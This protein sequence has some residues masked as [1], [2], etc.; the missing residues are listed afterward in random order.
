M[1][2]TFENRHVLTTTHAYNNMTTQHTY[3]YSTDM[4]WHSSSL[5]ILVW[6]AMVH[7]Q[8]GVS[9]ALIPICFLPAKLSKYQSLTKECL[10]HSI[11]AFPLRQMSLQVV[12]PCHMLSNCRQYQTLPSLIYYWRHCAYAQNRHRF[13]TVLFFSESSSWQ[14]TQNNFPC[15]T[16]RHLPMNSFTWVAGE[17]VLGSVWEGAPAFRFLSKP[18]LFDFQSFFYMPNPTFWAPLVYPE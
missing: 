18:V 8:Q 1:Y 7:S 4:Y 15:R 3:Q 12:P 9:C 16:S 11:L 6:A 2:R 13:L 10:S 5:Q 14:A 17:T